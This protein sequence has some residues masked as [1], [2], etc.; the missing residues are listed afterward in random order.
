MV[1][2]RGDGII[3]RSSLSAG[4]GYA[5]VVL[6]CSL[7]PESV[8]LPLAMLSAE[9]CTALRLSATP[10]HGNLHTLSARSTAGQSPWA[11]LTISPALADCR[12]PLR[13]PS[14]TRPSIVPTHYPMTTWGYFLWL[15]DGGARVGTSAPV[16]VG[17]AGCEVEWLLCSRSL[18]LPA[19]PYSVAFCLLRLVRNLHCITDFSHTPF[20]Y[21]HTLFPHSCRAGFLSLHLTPSHPFPRLTSAPRLHTDTAHCPPLPPRQAHWSHWHVIR[22]PATT[23]SGIK[24]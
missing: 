1:V 9:T 19:P 21:S 23:P 10:V 7:P 8:R 4:P 20:P 22:Q 24:A 12:S 14:I 11:P 6:P 18:A 16:A 5:P 15:I 17:D 3:G 2:L 13:S